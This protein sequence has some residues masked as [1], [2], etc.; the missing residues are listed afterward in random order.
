MKEY[1][2]D[3]ALS[4]SNLEMLDIINDV[5]EGQRRMGVRKMS[6][7]QLYYQ[8]VTSNIISNKDP[9]YKKIGHLLKEGR[10][11]GIVDWDAIEDRLRKPQR[12]YYVTDVADAIDDTV[13]YYRLDR[14]IGQPHNLLVI[15]EKDALSGVLSPTTDEYM[16]PILVNRGYGSCTAMHDLHVLFDQDERPGKIL[17][18]GDHDPS[19]LDMI[20][21]VKE[22]IGEFGTEIE[23]E[24]IALTWDQV[25]EFAP[26]PNPAKIKDPRAKNYINQFG[27]TSWEVDALEPPVLVSLL[28]AAIEEN[29]DMSIFRDVMKTEEEEKQTL[30]EMAKQWE[31]TNGK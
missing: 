15:V 1:F 6:L 10:M 12:P 2:R 11:A 24:H 18:I 14:Q 23:I 31:V 29:M 13:E 26:P 9:E 7:R 28:E 20:R 25:E 16:V 5:I 17:Y 4:K 27:G 19:G 21:D 3:A 30:M 8:L 22:R